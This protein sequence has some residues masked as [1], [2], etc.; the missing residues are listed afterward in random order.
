MSN[1]FI[2]RHDLLK[3]DYRI[4]EGLVEIDF[5]GLRERIE[6]IDKSSI[7]AVVGPY[8]S[9]KS[10]AINKLRV[11]DELKG[12]WLQFDAWRYPERKGL[13]DGLVIEIARQLGQEKKALR[14]LDGNK[15][16]IGRW[17]SPV[18]EFFEQIKSFFPEKV[19]E[20]VKESAQDASA[21]SKVGTKVAELFGKSPAKRTYELER[22][23]SDILLAVKAERIY[24]V[25]EDVDRSG[26]DGV[27][28]LETLSYFL[29]NNDQIN[30]KQI[31]CIVLVG[32]DSYEN[33]TDSYLKAVDYFEFFIPTVTSMGPF[34][35]AVFND[36]FF[37]Q[38]RYPEYK[39]AATQVAE[40]LEGV[41]KLYPDQMNMRKLK[42]ILRH[43]SVRFQRQLASGLNPDWRITM[44]MEF[45]RYMK[46]DIDNITV[47][48]P[49]FLDYFI[50][51][52][53]IPGNTLFGRLLYL[54]YVNRSSM[55]KDQYNEDNGEMEK[56]FIEVN[57]D[58][59]AAYKADNES[60]PWLLQAF[61]DPSGQSRV[62]L[63]NYYLNK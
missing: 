61:D 30:D 39:F 18:A 53:Y 1:D 43:A 23:L 3:E 2:K 32:D 28:F 51:A 34:I 60:R 8:G 4:G 31:I 41:L 54:I 57:N 55:Y 27:T 36:H 14:S 40:F 33:E 19:F 15:S 6:N 5:S 63:P 24:L 26:S 29:K 45:A 21:A 11:S 46:S 62:Y 25:I 9:G 47:Q 22:I 49:T 7:L 12:T 37:D 56:V 20:W 10:T 44:C 17:G 52:R 16:L 50:E 13:W 35:Q 42:L 58:F 48:P 38:Q 59:Y